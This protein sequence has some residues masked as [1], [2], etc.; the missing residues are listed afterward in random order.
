MIRVPLGI[1]FIAHGSQ[2][3]FGAFGGHGFRATIQSWEHHLG[4]PPFLTAIALLVEFFGGI[5]VLVGFWTRPAA[6]GLAACMAVAIVRVHEH[7]GFFINWAMV[8]GRGHGIEMNL[9]LLGM[10]LML[11][12][13]GPG[14]FALDSPD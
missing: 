10:C 2:H 14:R 4:V 1:I 11:L 9:A 12:V 13:D 7:N 8:E 3:L 6:L 5:A